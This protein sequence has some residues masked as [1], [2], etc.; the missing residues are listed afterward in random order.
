MIFHNIYQRK[1]QTKIYFQKFNR[2]K[3]FLSFFIVFF[4]DSIAYANPIS[5]TSI[6]K[7]EGLF[8]PFPLND[9]IN[10]NLDPSNENINLNSDPF[11]LSSNPLIDNN[12]QNTNPLNGIPSSQEIGNLAFLPSIDNSELNNIPGSSAET[13]ELSVQT[14]PL[15]IASNNIFENTSPLQSPNIENDGTLFAS[16]SNQG[17]KEQILD[18]VDK[19]IEL[20][21]NSAK[22]AYCNTPLEADRIIYSSNEIRVIAEFD[23]ENRE[24]LYN[25]RGTT[26]VTNIISDSGLTNY[27][28]DQNSRVHQGFFKIFRNNEKDLIEKMTEDIK[29]NINFA[30]SMTGFDSG[31]VYAIFT[32]LSLKL[33]SEVR[34]K[35]F[36]MFTFGQP[37]IGDKAFAQLVTENLNVRRVVNNNDV[38]PHNPPI[39]RGYQHFDAEYWIQ[40]LGS[41]KFKSFRC[42]RSANENSVSL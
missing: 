38:I 2:Q 33:H 36:N 30:L 21:G 27:P 11:S 13:S 18:G 34:Q 23:E 20:Y 42:V 1:H 10:F 19:T 25:F 28:Y 35:P 41:G 14:D 7:R 15:Q 17:G 37:R 24:I 31:G 16:N 8:E 40:P 12:S 4:F 39:D 26:Q 29:K 32:A 6:F 3:I 5:I 9:N 22:R